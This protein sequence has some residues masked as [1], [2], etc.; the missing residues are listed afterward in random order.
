MRATLATSSENV[1]F[2][3]LRRPSRRMRHVACPQQFT[4][5]TRLTPFVPTRGRTPAPPAPGPSFWRLDA[6]GTWGY[7][8]GDTLSRNTYRNGTRVRNVERPDA[9]GAYTAWCGFFE[10]MRQHA[11]CVDHI[12]GALALPMHS[13][14]AAHAAS[15]SLALLPCAGL[16]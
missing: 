6:D 3:G 12:C 9:R 16:A 14:T 5:N 15:T 1:A 8:A 7:K 11:A 4:R 10:V 13:T 2:G